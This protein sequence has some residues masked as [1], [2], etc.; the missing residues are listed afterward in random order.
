MVFSFFKKPPEKMVAKPAVAPREKAAGVTATVA[1]AAT[2]PPPPDKPVARPAT[3]PVSTPAAIPSQDFSDFQFSESPASFHIEEDLDPVQSE[4]EQA[5]ILYANGQDDAARTQLEGAVRTHHNGSAERLWLM[6]FDL[7]RLTGQKAAFEALE[8][9][10]AKFFEK[11]PPAWRDASKVVAKT[12]TAAAG[13]MLFKGELLGSNDAGFA[14]I[15]QA[16]EKNPKLRL[17]LSSIKELDAAGCGRLLTQLQLARKG[18]GD[19]ELLG[20]DHL[21]AKVEAR[22]EVGRAENSEYWLLLIELCQMQGQQEAFDEV[23]INYAVTF[24]VSPPSWE[25]KR[26]AAAE[27]PSVELSA[28]DPDLVAD[29]YMIRGEIKSARFND[30]ATF[31]KLHDP[32][33]LDCAAV[34][35]M[36]FVSAGVL[37]NV[38]TTIKH[39]GKIIVFRH[40]N[41]LLAELLGVVGLKTVAEV[42]LAKN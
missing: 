10:Y 37:L 9:D 31:A 41:H 23:A 32:V 3:S 6:L 5:A 4:A 39:N 34:T 36:D 2:A 19:I 38:L 1:A 26:I 30:L 29:T 15:T 21:G 35:R 27:P 28:V 20:R 22:V 17:D 42:V 7:Y 8:G 16:L 18:K 40:P 24:E 33:V 11:S 25:P 12:K 13:S 14:A